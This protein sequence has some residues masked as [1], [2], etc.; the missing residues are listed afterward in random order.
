[1][2]AAKSLPQAK[3]LP[4]TFEKLI[5]ELPGLINQEFPVAKQSSK[6]VASSQMPRSLVTISSRLEIPLSRRSRS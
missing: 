5:K 1:M 6:S 2:E 3:P 4:P